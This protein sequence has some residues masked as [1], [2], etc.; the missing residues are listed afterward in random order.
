MNKSITQDNKNNKQISKS[1]SRFFSKFHVSSA[2]KEFKAYK[3]K[4]IPVV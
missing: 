4:E 2:L 3:K 1:I